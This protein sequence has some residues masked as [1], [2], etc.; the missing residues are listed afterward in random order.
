MIIFTPN[1]V[2]TSTDVNANFEE[3]TDIVNWKNPYQFR[4]ARTSNQAIG[5]SAWT[6][7][8]FQTEYHDLNNN[9]DNATNYRYTVPVTGYYSFSTTVSFTQPDNNGFWGLGVAIDIYTS[10]AVYSG[11]VAVDYRTYYPGGRVAGTQLSCS[12]SSVY[13][14]AGQL[15]MVNAF[16][17]PYTNT[18]TNVTG[19]QFA[20]HLIST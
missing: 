15:V 3:V 17:D 7:V 10:G 9:Y 18:N 1:T 20:G 2:I 4:V 8:Q 12:C 6:K 5:D 13:L 16:A 14:E 19:G 11:N